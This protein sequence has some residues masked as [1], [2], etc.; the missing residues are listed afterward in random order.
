M[1][2][3]KALEAAGHQV[4]KARVPYPPTIGMRFSNRWLA[5]IAEDAAEPRCRPA[6]GAH[7]QDGAP[8]REDRAQG[9]A[10][11]G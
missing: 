7:P 6:G 3:T 8:R 5:G 1:E 2:A 9:E 4:T 11:R 10:G